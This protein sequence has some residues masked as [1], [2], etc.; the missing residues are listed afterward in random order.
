[1][2][3]RDWIEQSKLHKDQFS[4]DDFDLIDGGGGGKP[5]NS[6]MSQSD[7]YMSDQF[8]SDMFEKRLKQDLIDVPDD[9]YEEKIMFEDAD[10]LMVVFKDL[11]DKNL[12]K[13]LKT[14][15]TESQ[16]ESTR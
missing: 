7:N 12:T 14:Q 5:K 15:E 9:F 8:W 11:E 4:D 13:I 6:K 1:M 10:D 2:I 3:K 16:L